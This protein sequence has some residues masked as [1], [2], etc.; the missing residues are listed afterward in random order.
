[1]YSF[2]KM[3]L[4]GSPD[5]WVTE[6]S[7]HAALIG[8]DF[9]AY[10]ARMPALGNINAPWTLHNCP[11][12]LWKVYSQ[13]NARMTD[14]V[15]EYCR[16][17]VVPRTWIVP[18]P[19]EIGQAPVH[20]LMQ[21]ARRNGVT[22]GICIPIRDFGDVLS[23]LT[24]AS[25]APIA[26]AEIQKL[27]PIAVLFATYLHRSCA[28]HLSEMC[29]SRAPRLSPREIECLSWASAG[30]TSW[31]IGMLLDISERTVVFHLQNAATKLGVVGRQHAVAKSISLGLVSH[32]RGAFG[33]RFRA[34][35]A[36]SRSEM[37]NAIG[38][39]L[40]RHL[41]KHLS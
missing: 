5:K 40:P 35:D 24:L 36:G 20:E 37:P 31:E 8:F 17:D 23:S 15:P 34:H 27:R 11:P 26:D 9:W 39:E 14:P 21:A 2:E 25:K 7:R 30:K 6:I 1:M 28:R 3:Q 12:D 4:D 41:R 32:E 19:D 16:E 33:D 38:D 13:C 22:G 18:S 10:S 29:E